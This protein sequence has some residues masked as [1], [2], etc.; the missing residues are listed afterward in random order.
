MTDTSKF[1][2]A[3][4]EA[5]SKWQQVIRIQETQIINQLFQG[6]N[7][8]SIECEWQ[9]RA[10]TKG[11]KHIN[12]FCSLAAWADNITDLLTDERY[13]SLEFPYLN[14]DAKTISRYY[15]RFLLTASEYFVDFCDIY[16]KVIGKK[17][18]QKMIRDELSMPNKELDID[19]FFEFV[20][21]FIKHKTSTFHKCN[22]HLLYVYADSKY[23]QS[24]DI[25]NNHLID[26]VKIG[27]LKPSK[28]TQYIYLP[29]LTVI[30]EAIEYCYYKLIMALNDD[31]KFTRICEEF[32][33][34]KE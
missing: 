16:P 33:T 7:E 12:L 31:E 8:N 9:K 29:K 21:R 25:N 19:D 27:H 34:S 11:Y 32:K 3:R 23:L 2:D 28:D 24:F 5:L 14:G 17:T 20:N 22:Y 4:L 13:D 1:I 15:I 26:T 6:E 10:R 30:V 18:N